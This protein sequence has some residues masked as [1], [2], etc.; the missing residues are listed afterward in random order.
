[1]EDDE[2]EE[3]E[4]TEEVGESTSSS[5]YSLEREGERETGRESGEGRRCT[6]GAARTGM[7]SAGAEFEEDSVR[8]EVRL[9]GRGACGR[10]CIA[11]YDDG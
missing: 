5:S 9:A 4:E 8:E 7:R 11:L 2:P 3:L 6:C 1:M 10:C